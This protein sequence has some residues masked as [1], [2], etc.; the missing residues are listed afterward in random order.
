MI[1]TT[2]YSVDDLIFISNHINQKNDIRD[3]GWYQLYTYY[4]YANCFAFSAFLFFLEYY[5]AGFILFLINLFFFMFISEKITKVSLKQFYLN[6]FS[7]DKFK[8]TTIEISESGVCC[9]SVESHTFIQWNWFKE[10][11]ETENK[12][13]FFTKG[14]GITI[15][16]TSFEYNPQM[17]EFLIFAKARIPQYFLK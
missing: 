3:N 9:K 5:L 14:N 10:I 15:T 17:Q 2:K 4:F 7:D 8:E 13:Y 1:V 12:I 11:V 6:F 16:K